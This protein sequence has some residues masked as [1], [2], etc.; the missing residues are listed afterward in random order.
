MESK[1]KTPRLSLGGAALAVLNRV[2]TY[3][4]EKWF[5]I[6]TQDSEIS[7]NGI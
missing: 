3:L 2:T 6:A 5:F 1:I 7:T 4:C